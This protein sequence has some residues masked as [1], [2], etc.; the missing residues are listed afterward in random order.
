MKYLT[1]SI[2]IDIFTIT[3]NNIIFVS[4]IEFISPF[5]YTRYMMMFFQKS[6]FSI[7]SFIHIHTHL[8]I[9]LYNNLCSFTPQVGCRL[10]NHT[11]QFTY[12]QKSFR[13][14]TEKE[15]CIDI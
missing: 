15:S 10:D 1:Y 3:K 11:S 7:H 6:N 2:Y 9:H 12:T 4:Y 13:Y 5:F 14:R 8:L